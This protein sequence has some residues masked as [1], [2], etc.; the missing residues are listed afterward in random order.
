M[1]GLLIQLGLILND[2]WSN[3]SSQ[4]SESRSR[5]IQGCDRFGYFPLH[6]YA[7][8]S[9]RGDESFALEYSSHRRDRAVRHRRRVALNKR[10]VRGGGGQLQA[11]FC[12]GRSHLERVVPSISRAV[13][14]RNTRVDDLLWSCGP[15]NLLRG[16]DLRLGLGSTYVNP[17]LMFDSTT[18]AGRSPM[19]DPTPESYAVD[20]RVV[21]AAA[22]SRLRSR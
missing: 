12:L 2:P 9:D 10:N 16:T 8:G 21:T 18:V 6:R 7:L 20:G 13:E 3:E 11:S 4:H 19:L 1:L 15:I 5:S 17:H 14:L 22:A